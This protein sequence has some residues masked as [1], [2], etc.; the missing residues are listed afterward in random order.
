MGRD[1]GGGWGYPGWGWGGGWG[2]GF[3][4]GYPYWGYSPYAYGYPYYGY[5]SYP[6][7]PYYGDNYYND[8]PSDPQNNAD[9]GQYRQ[10]ADYSSDAQ[11]PRYS[12]GAADPNY[13]R[14]GYSTPKPATPAERKLAAMRPGVRNVVV[15]LQNMPP[16]ARERQLQ[17]GRYSNLS[18]KEVRV[19]RTAVNLPPA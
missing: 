8:P 5:P 18:Q 6:Y 1:W 12:S 16:E 11:Y 3:G 15:A 14:V 19:V 10:P 4:F 9:P 2:F 17:S 13:A 7:Y